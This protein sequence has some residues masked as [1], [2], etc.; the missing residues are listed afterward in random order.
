[1]CCE[2][3]IPWQRVK[4]DGETSLTVTEA[5]EPSTISRFSRLLQL[6]STH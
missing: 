1:M 3:T 4:N 5:A 6:A 2:L